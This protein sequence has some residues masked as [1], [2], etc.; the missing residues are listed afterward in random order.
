MHALLKDNPSKDKIIAGLHKEREEHKLDDEQTARLAFLALF[1]A[2]V[3][4]QVKTDKLEIIKEVFPFLF[5]IFFIIFIYS[6][7]SLP[8]FMLTKFRLRPTVLARLVCWA[9]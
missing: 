7:Y 3:F 8:T 2:N 1:D 4:K 9:V 6:S 5:F